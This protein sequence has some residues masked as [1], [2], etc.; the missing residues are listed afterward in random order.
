M[1]LALDDALR[2][3]PGDG[4]GSFRSSTSPGNQRNMMNP[5]VQHVLGEA[6]FSNESSLQ[7]HSV[8]ALKSDH[9][10]RRLKIINFECC[11]I[12]RTVKRQD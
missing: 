10:N 11:F 12:K 1:N 3:T 9:V 5:E 2:C 4:V 8:A 6:M 7:G